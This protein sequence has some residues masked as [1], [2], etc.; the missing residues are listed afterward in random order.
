[1]PV[2][3]TFTG[4]TAAHIRQEMLDLLGGTSRVFRF[5]PHDDVEKAAD[6]PTIDAAVTTDGSPAPAAVAEAPKARR[7]RSPK[8]A[9]PAPEPVLIGD[10]ATD[11][12]AALAALVDKA[13]APSISTT[14]ED[15]VSPDDVAEEEEA[16][17]IEEMTDAPGAKLT[18]DDLRNAAGRIN[19]ALGNN[20]AKAQE[21]AAPAFVKHGVKSISTCPD[22]KLEAMIVELNAIAAGVEGAK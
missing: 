21:L 15:R 2:E 3:I 12:S 19:R 10:G 6:A 18:V 8:N 7:G 17:G 16:D 4:E 9:E 5:K 1:M 11:D 20:P 22:D 14:P 13:A